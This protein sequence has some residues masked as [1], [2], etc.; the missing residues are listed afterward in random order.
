MREWGGGVLWRRRDRGEHSIT[1]D[2]CARKVGVPGRVVACQVEVQ[3]LCP[4]RGARVLRPR[5]K[6]SGVARRRTRQR[7]PRRGTRRHGFSTVTQCLLRDLGSD[8]K[9]PP[10]KFPSSSARL[11]SP[12]SSSS[13]CALAGNKN[14][15]TEGPRLVVKS[16][17]TARVASVVGTH[18]SYTTRWWAHLVKWPHRGRRP[19]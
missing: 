4:R 13:I 7:R 2:A 18:R 8:E 14:A 1:R 17:V 9:R 10:N 19:G 5:R 3:R 12:K 16:S 6:H 11:E 15:E